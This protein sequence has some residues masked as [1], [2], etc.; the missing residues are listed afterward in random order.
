MRKWVNLDRVPQ[1]Y[2]GPG[3]SRLWEL[4]LGGLVAFVVEGAA[5]AVRP[6]V[7]E[8]VVVQVPFFDR[9]FHE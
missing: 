4:V 1:S 7:Q 8:L 9:I 5:V 2:L 3:L 6:V